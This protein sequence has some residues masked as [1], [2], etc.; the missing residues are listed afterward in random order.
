MPNE[1]SYIACHQLA[2]IYTIELEKQI[3]NGEAEIVG[4]LDNNTLISV[5]DTILNNSSF[6][7]S[8]RDIREI[9][10]NLNSIII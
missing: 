9:V 6:I 5:R 3:L 2:P 8:I 10:R 7:L 4:R 1:E